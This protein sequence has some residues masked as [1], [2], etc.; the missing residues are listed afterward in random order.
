[1]T[2]TTEREQEQREKDRNCIRALKATIN[3]LQQALG[4]RPSYPVTETRA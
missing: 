2:A 3:E 1:M 4:I